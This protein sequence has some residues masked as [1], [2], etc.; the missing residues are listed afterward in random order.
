MVDNSKQVKKRV[1]WMMC[2]NRRS[3]I[4]IDEVR[5]FLNFAFSNIPTSTDEEE[6]KVPC[7]CKRCNNRHHKTRKEINEDLIINAI[8]SGYTRWIY[9]GEYE[10]PLNYKWY[11][12]WVH[13]MDLSW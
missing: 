6:Y 3:D 7:P 8:V 2:G 5:E 11:S 9:H 1:E 4:Y 13:S 10:P 12:I